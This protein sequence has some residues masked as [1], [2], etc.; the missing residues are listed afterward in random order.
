[1]LSLPLVID[2]LGGEGGGSQDP[3]L[4]LFFPQL[5]WATKQIED[6]PFCVTLGWVY[7]HN[8]FVTPQVTLA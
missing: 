2:P 1:M 4:S 7:A 8:L 6:C 5:E 3:K